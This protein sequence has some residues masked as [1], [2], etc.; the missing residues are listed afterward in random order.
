[1]AFSDFPYYPT[2]YKLGDVWLYL[3]NFDYPLLRRGVKPVST[4]MYQPG[5]M[6]EELETLVDNGP[7]TLTVI[8]SDRDGN[9]RETV[10][11]GI[12]VESVR[13]LHDGLDGC[14]VVLTDLRSLIDTAPWVNDINLVVFGQIV[15]GTGRSVS[16]LI[17]GGASNLFVYLRDHLFKTYPFEGNLSNDWFE[18]LNGYE[19]IPFDS[20]LSGDSRSQVLQK[21]LEQWSLDLGLAIDGTFYIAP[22]LL[23][24]DN[25]PGVEQL[26]SLDMEWAAPGPT[27]G[28]KSKTFLRAR[29]YRMPFWEMHNLQVWYG[30]PVFNPKDTSS[31]D[32]ALRA[33]SSGMILTEAYKGFEDYFTIDGLLTAFGIEYTVPELKHIKAVFHRTGLR[34]SI[35]SIHPR[36]AA[37]LQDR[38]ER[39][40][41]IAAGKAIV[42]S[43]RRL[44]QMRRDPDLAFTAHKSGQGGPGAWLDIELGRQRP[45]GTVV[46]TRP[47]G[48][49]TLLYNKPEIA[50]DAF[51]G[52]KPSNTQVFEEDTVII[53]R[54][55]DDNGIVIDGKILEPDV[56]EWDPD[57]ETWDEAKRRLEDNPFDPP[58]APYRWTLGHACPFTV[59]WDNPKAMVVRLERDER[60]LGE[61]GR[62]IM[63]RPD[64]Q[65]IMSGPAMLGEVIPYLR[66]ERDMAA[67]KAALSEDQLRGLQLDGY[68][69]QEDLTWFREYS[70]FII[71]TAR[72]NVPNDETKFWMEIRDG[73]DDAPIE[74]ITLL[75]NDRVFMRRQYADRTGRTEFETEEDGYGK[76]MNPKE[77]SNEADR[78]AAYIMALA[79]EPD[80]VNARFYNLNAVNNIKL[81]GSLDSVTLHVRGPKI[82]CELQTGPR[83]D[84]AARR[85]EADLQRSRM[86]AE[87]QGKMAKR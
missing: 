33:K 41:R 50:G 14:E 56:A 58:K 70:F 39:Q 75:P 24:D 49:W 60:D 31:Q 59:R 48:F 5:D 1:M 19:I 73:F 6:A 3:C 18:A 15:P 28:R 61:L 22:R 29:K 44:Y 84:D 85:V 27:F 13:W 74:E 62:A 36:D 81:A 53:G 23:D 68:I 10:I 35:L 4:V 16:D 2:Q 8:D 47:H 77:V 66:I 11:R 86:M 52:P 78:R 87:Y 76:P 21:L 55:F 51:N 26:K 69:S 45:D 43:E 80:P 71:V 67:D 12:I 30:D 57:R 37:S 82:E 34:G 17:P 46:A 83:A 65:F 63:G 25:D 79:N 72:R 40:R 20:H 38:S 32:N 42:D 64:Q 7:T 54:V 9:R